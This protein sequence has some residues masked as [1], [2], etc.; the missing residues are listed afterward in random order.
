VLNTRK[1]RRKK[2]VMFR[3]YLSEIDSIYTNFKMNAHQ[4]EAELLKIKEQIMQEFKDELIDPEKY[5]I[6]DKRLEDYL[7]EIRKEIAGKKDGSLS[8]DR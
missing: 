4:C 8:T 7:R 5:T 2:S 3:E 1:Q 6:L